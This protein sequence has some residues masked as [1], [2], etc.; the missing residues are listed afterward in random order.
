MAACQ[1]MGSGVAAAPLGLN[2]GIPVISCV[3][4]SRISAR[5]SAFSRQQAARS[6]RRDPAILLNSRLRRSFCGASLEICR[7]YSSCAFLNLALLRSFSI[8]SWYLSITS[9]VLSRVAWNSAPLVSRALL[10]SSYAC[11][12]HGRRGWL[13]FRAEIV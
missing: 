10:I 6:I 9:I 13:D 1:K 12:N 7:M 5:G 3:G 2:T 4:G 8:A 11:V